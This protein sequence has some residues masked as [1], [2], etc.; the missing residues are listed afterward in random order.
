M[1]SIE[2]K[3]LI[4]RDRGG[5]ER[6]VVRH[7]IRY[8]DHAGREHSETKRRLVDAERRKAELEVQLSSGAWRDPRRDEIHLSTW[9]RD[10]VLTR[11]D[12]R[13]STRARLEMTLTGHVIPRFGTTPLVKITNADVRLWVTERLARGPAP[14]TVR[15]AAFALRQCLSAAMADGRLLRNRA[16]DVPLPSERLKPP[17]FLSQ[18]EVEILA[19]AMPDRYRGL[20]LVGAYAGLRWGELPV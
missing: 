16:L 12:Q 14:T 5:R 15:R 1:A 18:E 20:V 17:R 2:R 10:W 3:R 19:A 13:P 6:T 7:K 9:A 8:R 4:E 11:H